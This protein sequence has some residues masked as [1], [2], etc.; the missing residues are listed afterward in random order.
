MTLRR[1]A[2]P[3]GVDVP[4]LQDVAALA[5]VSSATASRVLSGSL[6]P[7][8]AP[9]RQKVLDATKALD[10]EPNMLARGL[11][12]NR[13]Q[14]VAVLVHDIMDEYFSEI[15]RGVEDEAYSHG[16]VA[17]ICNTDRDADKELYYLRK[18][19]AMQIDAI[20]F[21]A[22]G[23]RGRTHRRDANRQLT[24]IEAA[25]GVIVRLAPHPGGKPDVGYSNRRGLALAV[26]HLVGL[27][28]RNIGFLAGSPRITTSAERLAAMRL[29]L[30]SHGIE[31]LEA[32]IFDGDFSRAGGE[33][34]AA[35]FVDADCAATAVVS[36]NDQAAIGFVRGL[37]SRHVVVPD[38]VSVVGFDDIAPC[39]YVEPPLTTV[40]VPLY[41]IGVQGMRLAFDLLVGKDRPKPHEFP[42]E[43]TIR[44]TTAPP[45]RHHRNY[46]GT[47]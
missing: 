18:L 28:H 27:G 29:A 31:L 43:L 39:A 30:A 34:A 23:L 22:G 38:E 46:G 2:G 7:V 41:E 3:H 10:F 20:L 17:L 35:K 8:A 40:H 14:T 21:T 26:D 33:E 32:T 13:T 9:T 42:L 44:S 36:A 45:P 37:R 6:H 5:G 24:Q 47:P 11:A 1:G 25:G 15:A 12:R 16:Y 4:S 19:R